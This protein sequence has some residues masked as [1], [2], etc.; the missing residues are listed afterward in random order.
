MDDP[1][2]TAIDEVTR[3]VAAAGGALDGASASLASA[4]ARRL[5]GVPM[6]ILVDE[7]LAVGGPPLRRSGADLLS[8]YR[9]AVRGFRAAAVRA[10]VDEDGL[11]LTEVSRRL[12][13]SRQM[14]TRLYHTR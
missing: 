11:S 6:T 3:A 13:I 12:E 7:L 14:A 5:A 2:I 10:L 9:R 8:D 1:F 4:R